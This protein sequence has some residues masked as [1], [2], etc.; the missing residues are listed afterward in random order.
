MAYTFYTVRK[1][2]ELSGKSAQR[3]GLMCHHSN[4]PHKFIQITFAFSHLVSK[5]VG[6]F[7]AQYI[8][9]RRNFQHFRF[10]NE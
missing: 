10:L 2:V 4:P 9:T 7:A 3:L 6:N 1:A 5:D 8:V